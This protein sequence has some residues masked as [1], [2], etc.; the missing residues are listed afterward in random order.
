MQSYAMKPSATPILSAALWL[1]RTEEARDL[2]F[3]L[4][5]RLS[6]ILLCVAIGYLG[7]LGASERVGVGLAAGAA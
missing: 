3:A 1:R 5:G 7:Y 6:P 4:V 2:L